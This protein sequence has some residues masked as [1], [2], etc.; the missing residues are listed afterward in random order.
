MGK[1]INSAWQKEMLAKIDAHQQIDVTSGFTKGITWLVEVLTRRD[2]PFALY[3]AGAGVKRV[4]TDT[5]KCPCCKR[6][7][8]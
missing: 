5:E 4:T 8:G 2:I 6:V 1:V 3:N 7:L